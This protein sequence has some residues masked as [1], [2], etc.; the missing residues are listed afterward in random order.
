MEEYIFLRE[1]LLKLEKRNKD[2]VNNKEESSKFENKIFISNS[3]EPKAETSKEDK[4][5]NEQISKQDKISRLITDIKN[6][7]ITEED[8]KKKIFEL[9]GEK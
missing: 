9:M 3:Q 6:S 5:L 4:D 7:N 2:L 8:A 1:E